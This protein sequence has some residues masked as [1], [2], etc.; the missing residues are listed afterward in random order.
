MF[1]LLHFLDIYCDSAG[2]TCFVIMYGQEHPLVTCG[3]TPFCSD[4]AGFGE[5]ILSTT[6]LF[7]HL[8]PT[9][10]LSSEGD[11][12][13]AKHNSDGMKA[14]SRLVL[15]CLLPEE[16]TWKRVGVR[17]KGSDQNTKLESKADKKNA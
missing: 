6:C 8:L 3:L 1:R 15:L 10:K 14:K 17:W 16:K 7:P 9:L 4:S 12:S 11:K 5:C 2:K 13:S